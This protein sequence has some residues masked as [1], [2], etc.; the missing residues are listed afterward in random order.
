MG[1]GGGGGVQRREQR[2]GTKTTEVNKVY[3]R[4]T[5]GVRKVYAVDKV[6]AEAG[7]FKVPKEGEGRGQ[8]E[9][10]LGERRYGGGVS[11]SYISKQG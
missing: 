11:V 2:Q 9:R 10:V 8:R 1:V 5:Q 6:A 4:C 7:L 3:A